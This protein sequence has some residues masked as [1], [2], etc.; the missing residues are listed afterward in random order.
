[1]SYANP[2][3]KSIVLETLMPRVIT[4]GCQPSPSIEKMATRKAQVLLFP[5]SS[6]NC[7]NLT[8]ENNASLSAPRCGRAWN[9]ISFRLWNGNVA[10]LPFVISP[11]AAS[12]C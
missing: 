2:Q 8:L 5:P 4:K 7:W 12:R 11:T 9:T 1:M 10:G 3:T 6:T